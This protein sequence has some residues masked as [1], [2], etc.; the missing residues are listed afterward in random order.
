[1]I[2]FFKNDSLKIKKVFWAILPGTVCNLRCSYCY[3][4]KDG[5]VKDVKGLYKYDIETIKAGLTTERLGGQCLAC[6]V[7]NGE[8]LLDNNAV[9]IIKALL[10]NGHIVEIVSNGTLT[11][12]IDE[13]LKLE[14]HL[15]KR[16]LFMN[17]FHYLEFKR[18]NML[19]TV[20]NN[21]TRMKNAGISIFMNLTLN[22]DYMPHLDEIKECC[23]KRLGI[24]PSIQLALD[25]DNNWKV[26]KFYT[27]EVADQV[28]K[29]FDA[30]EIKIND[31]MIYNVKRTEDCFAGAWSFVL[32]LGIGIATP[33]FSAR[34]GINIFDDVSKPIDFKPLRKCPAEFCGCGNLLQ[35][36]G[37]IPY[38]NYPSFTKFY[39]NN[40]ILNH[41]IKQALSRK[42]VQ[43]NR[44]DYIRYKFLW[45]SEK[46]KPENWKWY[47][48]ATT[49]KNKKI[50]L[51]NKIR[52]KLWKHL[53]KKLRKKGIIQ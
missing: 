41:E 32:S 43:N 12:R 40:S 24:I 22:K 9:P 5:H 36:L 14:P 25:P 26:G 10:E 45:I 18:L 16:I 38:L 17:S 20:F 42:F 6:V 52:Y 2:S 50:S 15:L 29:K 37:I 46:F 1:M 48:K 33:C 51:H 34:P 23:Q 28:C 53:D 7:S 49:L 27:P 13:L 19:D 3:V 4:S 47:K 31:K 8:T 21:M 35:Y 30:K 39:K 11:S 44:A